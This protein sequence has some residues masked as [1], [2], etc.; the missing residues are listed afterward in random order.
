MGYLSWIVGRVIIEG[1]PVR[2]AKVAQYRGRFILIPIAAEFAMVAWDLSQEPVWATIVKAWIWADGG[3]YF[4]VPLSN[5]AGWFLTVYAIYQL[6]ALYIERRSYTTDIA[7]QPLTFWR[8]PILFYALCAAGN[9]LLVLGPQKTVSDPA[10]AVWRVGDITSTCA[11]VSIF[12]MGALAFI[13]FSRLES[14]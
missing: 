8:L 5:F 6:F 1:A 14:H 4:G 11:L 13:A 3:P 9:I 12:T 10:G 7:R 2:D